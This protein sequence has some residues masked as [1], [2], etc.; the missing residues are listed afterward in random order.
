[1]AKVLFLN[2]KTVGK[3]MAGPGIRVW[4]LAKVIGKENKVSIILPSKNVFL[5]I[6]RNEII[7]FPIYSLDLAWLLL[8]RLL[9][10]KIVI[11][12]YFVPLFENIEKYN[13][14]PRLKKWVVNISKLRTKCLLLTGDLVLCASERQCS[15]WLEQFSAYGRK[16][17]RMEIAP[18]GI[19]SERPIKKHD[20]IKGIVPGISR[21]DKVVLWASG[22]WPWLDPMTA[23][24]AIR[25]VED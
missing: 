9:R 2:A 1:M 15:Y 16:A 12:A 10:K 24:K 18:T 23:I 13:G 21:D 20:L 14:Q 25:L 5:E 19:R 4:E 3:D 8:A 17:A 11:D 22:L 6:I 7:V